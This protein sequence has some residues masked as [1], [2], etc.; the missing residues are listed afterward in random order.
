MI[1]ILFQ[2]IKCFLL[3]LLYKDYSGIPYRISI[4][5]NTEFSS[6]SYINIQGL[7]KINKKKYKNNDYKF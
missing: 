1:L 7:P 4:L 3:E 2:F 5:R 6:K